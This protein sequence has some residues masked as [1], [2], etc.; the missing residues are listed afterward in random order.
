M[1][2][3]QR[4]EG[5]PAGRLGQAVRVE[6]V[7]RVSRPS[8]DRPQRPRPTARAGAQVIGSAEIA[9]ADDGSYNLTFAQE[10]KQVVLETEREKLSLPL[11]GGQASTAGYLTLRVQGLT[12]TPGE[13]PVQV[14]RFEIQSPVGQPPLA[15][16]Q[17]EK[18]IQDWA[19]R[20]IARNMKVLERF[21]DH[22]ETET[23]AGRWGFVTDMAVK[24]GLVRVG[25]E[26]EVTLHAT[27][28]L[29]SPCELRVEPDFLN[30]QPGAV[31]VL[32]LD[33]QD[34]GHG[35][36][37]ARVRVTPRR[38]GN[39]R[40]VWKAGREELSRT[41]AVVDQGFLVCRF[42][43][44][45]HKGP[46]MPGHE[47]EAYDVI[48]QHG[49]AA[50][51]WDGAEWV[52]PFSRTPDSLL[53]HF[54]FFSQ[55]RH[56]YGDR[57]M[58]MCNAN[59]MLPGSPDTNLWRLDEDV[60]R[61]GLQQIARLWDILG[62]G[63]MEILASYTFG[64]NTARIARDS[65]VKI[66]D[67]LV[68]W[69]NWRD[70]G[71]DNA[72]LI[73]QWGAPTVPY[74]VADD[75]FRK[76]A[77]GRSILAFTQA[78]TSSMRIYYINTLEGEPQLS[79]MRRHSREMGETSNID[80]FQTTVDLW[81]AEASYQAEP[82][83]VSVG[84]ENF[85]DS[86]DWNEANKRGVA[87][88]I[89]KAKTK[90]VVFAS[91]ADIADYYHRHYDRQPEHWFCWPDVY[92]GYQ[93]GYKPRQVPDR[94]EMANSRF[95]CEH[96]DGT[97]LPRFF[98]DYTRAWSEPVWDDQR[99]IR[100]KFGLVNPEL[101]TAENCVP[102]MVDLTG[103]QARAEIL[104]Q[105]D[106]AEIR[107]HLDSPRPIASL[108]VAIWRIPL[109]AQ[110][111]RAVDVS[112]N[113]RF[114]RVVDGSTENLHGIV[115]CQQVPSGKSIRTVRLTGAPR[116]TLD[117]AVRIGQHVRGRIFLRA[118]QPQAY[119]WLAEAESPTGVLKVRVPEGRTVSAHDNAGHSQS[120]TA[121]RLPSRSTAHG[122]TSH[123]G[124]WV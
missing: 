113:T 118:G 80:R 115:V 29:P 109:T 86:P 30:A 16:A 92:A 9:P 44:T 112:P 33:W 82:L 13:K 59:W 21:A 77:P 120:T 103:F 116:Q 17:R 27:G 39:W 107:V 49:L 88:L 7:R 66:L 54:G 26:V 72:W 4:G 95:H 64:N 94:I 74:F 67:S 1:G 96:V 68:Q 34:D 73:N 106:G 99:A 83:V 101:V 105:S 45:S 24:P 5:R 85:V 25:E 12:R 51:Y 93:A 76:V 70:G 97:A 37:T 58:P 23:K 50:D 111:L 36:K 14:R 10:S 114:V 124:S 15:A 19:R 100:Q 90:K 119:L 6:P 42:L 102:R 84:L 18:S 2:L 69:Q 56:R 71:D 46:W 8:R 55:G 28:P 11:P 65:G 53:S 35:A 62:L 79:C 122:R 60:Q 41:L 81:L 31:E 20:R 91:A 75:D 87:Y 3:R 89:E 123:P 48:H 61:D 32:A 110:G 121:A 47:P 43:I 98:W 78:T 22:V 108:P 57:V 52:S 63:P 38:P 104:P 117:P 40:F